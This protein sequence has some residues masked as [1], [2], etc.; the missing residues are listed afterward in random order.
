VIAVKQLYIAWSGV[1]Y[2]PITMEATH[3]EAWWNPV[4]HVMIVATIA[5]VLLSRIGRSSI[6]WVAA[7]VLAI[8]VGIFSTTVHAMCA[9][10]NR[11]V[12]A[13]SPLARLALTS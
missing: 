11:S 10:K 3:P 6:F 8:F 13:C 5:I 2:N 7:G 12:Q 9:Y 1:S 4:F